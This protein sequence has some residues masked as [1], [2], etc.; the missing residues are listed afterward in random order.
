MS[1]WCHERTH[2]L[3][4]ARRIDWLF[5]H[6]VSAAEQRQRKSEA[7]RLGCLEIDHE[8]DFHSQLNRE[9]ARLFTLENPARVN[10][11][12][13]ISVG[14]VATI[15]HQAAGSCELV[16]KVHRRHRVA[17]GERDELV[18]LFVE[19]RIGGKGQ[20]SC[21]NSSR[22]GAS[23]LYR[24]LVPVTLPPGRLMLETRPSLTGSP[25]IEK[26]I[27]MV[28]VAALAASGAAALWIA[29]ITATWRRTR[30]AA[31]AGNRSS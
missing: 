18:A 24:K 8:L 29:T 16:R 23:V 7:K 30:S 31:S 14:H 26:T 17:R 19:D 15:A 13:T 22:L 9:I 11:G 12:Q 1:A 6:L 10:A 25:P 27:G 28:A 3:Q 5:N 21:S 20:R 2:A 4:Q